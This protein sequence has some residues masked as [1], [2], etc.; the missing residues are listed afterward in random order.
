[1]II[2]IQITKVVSCALGSTSE[3]IWSFRKSRPVVNEMGPQG[4]ET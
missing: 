4:R 1:M 3:E 2:I